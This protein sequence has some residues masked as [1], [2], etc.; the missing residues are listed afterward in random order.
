[1][2]YKINFETLSDNFVLPAGIVDQDFQSLDSVFLKVIVMIYKNSA[3]NYSVNLLSNLL[4]IPENKIIQAI[5]Y[6]TQKGILIS[7][8]ED[9]IK[10]E[11]MVIAKTKPTFKPTDNTELKFLLECMENIL[12]RPVTSVEH[13]TIV[14]ILEF[15]RLPADVIL[16]AIEYCISIDKV[17]ARYIEK[18]C[19]NW[20]DKGITTHEAAE[21]Y[22]NFIKHSKITESKVQ[23]MF[24]LQDR[25]LIDSEREFI[26]KWTDDFK[27]DMDVIKLAYER[28]VGAIGKVAFAYINKILETWSERGYTSIEDIMQNEGKGKSA[29]TSTQKNTSYDIDELDRFWDKVPKLD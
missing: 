29:N 23:K 5:N 8:K 4:N 17:N 3:K 24:G 10:P 2:S 22:L 13:K 6:W 19:L 7:L 16:M 25:N 14:H 1:M 28:T 12:A 21:Q 18:V 20:A 15:V 26:R 9:A 27:F 11:I